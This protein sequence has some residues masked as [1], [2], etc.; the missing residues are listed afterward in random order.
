MASSDSEK[1]LKDLEAGSNIEPVPASNERS[2]QAQT[3][4]GWEGADDPRDPYNWPSYH[5]ISI[6][7]I[8]SIGQL[9]TLMSA[10][11]M[12]AVLDQISDDLSMSASL[13]QM[14]FSVYVLGLAFG[15]FIIGPMSEL[16]GR[17]PVWIIFNLGYV[18]WN[19]LCPVGKSQGVMIAGRL[20]TGFFA[21]AGVALTQPV[22]A[23]MYRAKDRGKSLALATFIP[24]LG[25]A[26]GPI[27][28]G[29]VAQHVEWSWLFWILSIFDA[30]VI[31][32]GTFVIRETCAFVLLRRKA[33][34][35]AHK[36]AGQE[37]PNPTN[38]A[39]LIAIGK[40]LLRP[41][42]LLIYRPVILF[43]SFNIAINFG[44]Y[45]LL[46]STFATLWIE[47]YHE[48]KSISS[49]N[50]IAIALGATVAAQGGGHLMDFLWRRQ[51]AQYPDKE[52]VP[53]F[54]VPYMVPCAALLPATL[55][56][57]GW[58]VENHVHWF[59]VD[60][61]VAF[62]A[63]SSFMLNQGMSAYMLDEFTHTASANAAV[64]LLSQLLGFCFPLFAPQMYEEL[65]YGWGNSLLAFIFIV[66]GIPQI[67]ILWFFGARI[68][69]IGKNR[70]GIAY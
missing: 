53:E 22:L 46:L 21:S 26:L 5:K 12:A 60:L 3:N 36:A 57:Y 68:R 50:Y 38:K 11:M 19:A 69:G 28:G 67:I 49:L 20:L 8:F 58:T 35:E 47:K 33:A 31:A 52:A 17:K 18:L 59:V 40:G 27:V 9:I 64:R 55:F 2:E 32:A 1:T 45:F 43:I 63:L 30:G 25:P 24:Y 14:S 66:V 62:F 7:I 42:E 13:T 51:K 10:S 54:R 41:V 70:A 39:V 65:G 4:P 48:S 23:D 15:P 34:A 61:S 56:W 37:L 44:T 29:L 6:A 16:Y